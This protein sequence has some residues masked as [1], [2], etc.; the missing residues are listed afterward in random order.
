[1]QLNQSWIK[2]SF[3][4][5]LYAAAFNL[6]WLASTSLE[7]IPNVVSWYLPA[8]LRI[9][10]FL[11]V[12]IRSWP[13]LV[14]VDRL[15]FFA[16]FHSGGLFAA[17]QYYAESLVWYVT[18]FLLHPITFLFLVWQYR[19]RFDGQLLTSLNNSVALLILF[20]ATSFAN[21]VL[22]VGRRA[23]DDPEVARHLF[24]NVVNM[25]L[26]DLVGI[27]VFFPLFI[28]LRELLIHFDEKVISTITQCTIVWI[29]ILCGYLFLTEFSHGYDYY[30]K[31]LAIVPAIFF[32]IRYGVVG[33]MCSVFFLCAMTYMAALLTHGPTLES[34]FYMIA[35]SMCCM[36]LGAAVVEQRVTQ[37]SLESAN[38]DLKDTNRVLNQSLA[39]NRL[40]SVKLI[41]SQEDERKRLS[42]DLHDDFGQKI[43]E[44]K[45]NAAILKSRVPESTEYVGTLVNTAN[46]LYVSLKNSIGGLSPPGLDEF[47]LSEILR[48]GDVARLV[49]T[50]GLH[51]FVDIKGNDSKLTERQRIN[52]YRIYQESVNNALKY[53]KGEGIHVQLECSETRFNLRI[54]DDGIGFDIDKAEK[55]FG[56]ISIAERANSLNAEHSIVSSKNGTTVKISISLN[57]QLG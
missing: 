35:M 19:K 9:C 12:P 15:A 48:S 42:M 52:L 4:G 14:V 33:A 24:E 20:A 36:F 3:L 8:G 17:P 40:L 55:G 32:S 10:V 13:Y 7:L 31:V 26:G 11:F 25:A 57:K 53:A 18:H 45:I 44:I 49:E 6:F 39:N 37:I 46:D 54:S 16:L 51:Y 34:Q 29:L 22:F 50:K 38:N 56:L 2:Y 41:D 28:I 5:F 47:G 23:L 43:S 1:M 21:A 30:V 27:F